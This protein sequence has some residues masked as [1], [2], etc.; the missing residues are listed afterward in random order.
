L[1][2]RAR[3]GGRIHHAAVVVYGQRARDE[4]LDVGRGQ[5][6]RRNPGRRRQSASGQPAGGLPRDLWR[7]SRTRGCMA[8]RDGREPAGRQAGA[9]AVRDARRRPLLIPVPT[10]IRCRQWM[11]KYRTTR[12]DPVVPVANAFRLSRLLLQLATEI[13]A[14]VRRKNLPYDWTSGTRRWDSRP[15]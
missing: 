9:L 11:M 2:E 10:V 14:R 7:P 6:A 3:Q 12:R 1:G 4:L 15:G 13:P 8:T 5:R